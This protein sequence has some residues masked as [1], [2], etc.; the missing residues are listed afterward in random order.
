MERLSGLSEARKTVNFADDVRPISDQLISSTWSEKTAEAEPLFNPNNQKVRSEDDP[1]GSSNHSAEVPSFE[2]IPIY[3]KLDVEA[4]AS[5]VD[6]QETVACTRELI[7]KGAQVEKTT[8]VTDS[9][10]PEQE[11]KSC[12][13][14]S[15]EVGTE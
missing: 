15:P 14:F 4:K 10:I 7:T 6:E 3:E 9:F 2:N 1:Q 11:S 5:K 12:E 13:E 8:V